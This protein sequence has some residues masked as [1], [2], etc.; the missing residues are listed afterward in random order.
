MVLIVSTDR[1][2]IFRGIQLRKYFLLWCYN[3]LLNFEVEGLT[4]VQ[5]WIFLRLPF[6]GFLLSCSCK[7]D[8]FLFP[9]F[10]TVEFCRLVCLWCEWIKGFNLE[11][12][13]EYHLEYLLLVVLAP[14]RFFE[15]KI[16]LTEGARDDGLKYLSLHC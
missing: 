12:F 8:W 5:K 16:A 15:K 14:L 2:T 13:L 9:T 11:S 3:M 4:L 6:P 1:Q 7:D 10:Q